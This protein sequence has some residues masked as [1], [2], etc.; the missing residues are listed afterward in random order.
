MI[1]VGEILQNQRLKKNL[2]LSDIEKK[3]KIRLKY[4]EAIEKNNWDIFSSKIYIIGILKNYSRLLDLDEKKVLAFFRRDYEKKEDIRFKRKIP[5]KYLN[6]EAKEFLK[7]T[8][9]IITFLFIIYFS[10]QFYLY[11]SPPKLTI[12][13]PKNTFFTKED[14]IKII[15]KTAPETTIF[16]ANQQVYQN[17]EGI[18]EYE[19][20]LKDGDN[21]L[22]IELIGANGKKIKI[23]KKFIKQSFK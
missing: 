19:F 9:F 20:P 3:L 17:K 10:Y 22:T 23:E 15:G 11:L 13:S 7:K 18:F 1:T 12:L 14:K 16:I 8:I 4:I 6:P 5:S 2:K 21:I